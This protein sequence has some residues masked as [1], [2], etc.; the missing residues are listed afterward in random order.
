MN[1]MNNNIIHHVA[2]NVHTVVVPPKLTLE[3]PD[4]N[5]PYNFKLFDNPNLTFATLNIVIADTPMI[6]H[7]QIIEFNVDISGS[8]GDTCRDG[9]S[10][11]THAS[12]TLKNIAKVL[13]EG[14]QIYAR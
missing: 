3:N 9:K 7:E 2:V 8:M 13:S 4:P 14:L 11:M 12:H 5:P 1:T 6:S 10:K